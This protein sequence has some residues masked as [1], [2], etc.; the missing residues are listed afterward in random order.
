MRFFRTSNNFSSSK[1]RRNGS[2]QN[3]PPPQVQDERND[4]NESD[5]R[6]HVRS[7]GEPEIRNV[8]SELFSIGSDLDVQ[9]QFEIIVKRRNEDK[10]TTTAE[11]TK[12]FFMNLTQNSN[13]YTFIDDTSTISSLTTEGKMRFRM[14]KSGLMEVATSANTAVGPCCCID[15]CD[16]DNKRNS[17]TA[18]PSY[19][20]NRMPSQSSHLRKD[21]NR[22]SNS[23]VPLEYN[24]SKIS[25]KYDHGNNNT[26]YANSIVQGT[27]TVE[28]SDYR[29]EANVITSAEAS[30]VT[31]AVMQKDRF[32]TSANR[33]NEILAQYDK[34]AE[35]E[36]L[37]KMNSNQSKNNID[38]SYNRK[39]SSNGQLN[40]GSSKCWSQMLLC[41]FVEQ[42]KDDM[43]YCDD[44]NEN[45]GICVDRNLR[46]NASS[47]SRRRSRRRPSS[48][49]ATHNTALFDTLS[50]DEEDHPKQNT[51]NNKSNRHHLSNNHEQNE[52][53][54]NALRNHKLTRQGSGLSPSQGRK[55]GGNGRK[56]FSATKGAFRRSGG[57][58]QHVFHCGIYGS[59]ATNNKNR[60]HKGLEASNSYKQQTISMSLSPRSFNNNEMKDTSNQDWPMAPLQ[61]QSSNS[62]LG[63]GLEPLSVHPPGKQKRQT[64]IIL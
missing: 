16:V 14:I 4:V 30:N 42:D 38:R 23:P 27:H 25:A 45:D 62:S 10:K 24:H 22:K 53:V 1:K 12:N 43:N 60:Q 61:R 39:S 11:R 7:K 37:N 33:R 44:R 6:N 57:A 31:T 58:F 3:E 20:M 5:N 8:K 35:L 2:G 50:D 36:R 48:A 59:G 55:R 34:D 9:D 15:L 54:M 51:N 29:Q 28:A 21:I 63:N 46:E 64:E 49:S 18:A 26:N 13:T 47:S 52:E 32:I 41:C 56:L 19:S 40:T 17:S